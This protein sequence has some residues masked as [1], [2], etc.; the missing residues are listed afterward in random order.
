MSPAEQ[1]FLLNSVRIETSG[2]MRGDW[3]E[4][5]VHLTLTSNLPRPVLANWV[6]MSILLCDHTPTVIGFSTAGAFMSHPGNKLSGGTAAGG[7]KKGSV[8]RGSGDNLNLAEKEKAGRKESV[9]TNPVLTCEDEDI[10]LALMEANPAVL[11][12]DFSQQLEMGGGG[13]KESSN[14]NSNK[15]GG[16]GG[17]GIQGGKLMCHD[18]HQSLR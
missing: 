11:K 8:K 2:K 13:G 7:G 6:G 12:L 5:I 4:V 9:G 14:N 1:T 16:G 15:G 17:G 10:A 18:T 3:A